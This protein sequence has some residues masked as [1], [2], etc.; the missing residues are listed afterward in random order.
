M[1]EPIDILSF[2]LVI[3]IGIL[4]GIERTSRADKEGSTKGAGVRTFAI[5]SIVGFFLS[6]I[7]KDGH[8]NLIIVIG[9]FSFLFLLIALLRVFEGEPG[10]TTSLTLLVVFLVGMIIGLG[11]PLRGLLIALITLGLT[12]SKKV[13]HRFAHILSDEELSSALRFLAVGVILIPIAYTI[14]PVNPLV[15]PGRVFDPFKGLTMVLF[16]SSISFTSY[17]V[18][19]FFGADK[20]MKISAFVGGL[21]SSAAATASLSER[22]KK[23]P[24]LKG[25]SAVGILI[26]NSSMFIKDFIIIF[27]VGGIV[28]A[29]KFTLPIGILLV[30]TVFLSLYLMRL[31][32]EKGIFKSVELE[33]DTPFALKPAV[34]FALIFSLIWSSTYILKNQFGGLGVYIVSI[35]GLISTTSVSASIASM[36]ASGEVTSTTA[37]STVLLSFGLSFLSKIFIARTY[38]SSLAKRITIPM[39]ITTA[40]TMIMAALLS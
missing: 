39:G 33:L 24:E 3:L 26:T 36:Y 23:Y 13:L 29:T 18:I 25:T 7:V 32:K 30:S 16:V 15:G 8:L 1:I 35:G 14:G 34:K 21:V 5:A 10:M 40:L 20:G 31:K 37:V 17:L 19:K 4:A 9:I 2:I 11:F 28:L 38:S 6:S 22:C 27:T 12:S